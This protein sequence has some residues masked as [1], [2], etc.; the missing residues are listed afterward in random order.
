MPPVLKT[1]L[2]VS[3]QPGQFATVED[4]G[5]STG[6]RFYVHSGTGGSGAG[7]GYTPS[8][9]LTTLAAAVALCTAN[10]GDIIYLMPGHAESIGA[11]GI[12]INV[13]GISIIGLGTGASRPTF[14]WHTTDAVL[15]ISAAS[16]LLHNFI[17]TVDIDEV[18]SMILVTGAAVVIDKV[19]HIDA[20]ATQAIQW[21]LTTNAADYLTI[22]NCFHV[23]NTAAASAQKWIQLVGPDYARIIDNI[24]I[25]TLN[26]ST[27]SCTISGSTAVVFATIARNLIMQTGAT[28]NTVVNCVTGSTGIISDNRAGSGTSVATTG[29]FTGD[30]MFMFENKWA[31]SAAASGLLA[32]AVDTDT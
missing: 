30:G 6:S 7:C 10:K 28:I 18:V 15:T 2:A 32:P 4:L 19:D 9:P 29:A 24:F 26:A 25:L 1:D 12:N 17:T 14:T 5:R 3:R 16:V 27:S 31:D 13:A 8:A 11:A 22:R 21:L 20:G 23:Q